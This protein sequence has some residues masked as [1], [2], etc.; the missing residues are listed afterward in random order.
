MDPVWNNVNVIGSIYD[1]QDLSP[2]GPDLKG[3]ALWL[4]FK[5]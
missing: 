4:D 1:K 3:S 5:N 2:G